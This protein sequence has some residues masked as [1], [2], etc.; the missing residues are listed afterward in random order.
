[1]WRFVT[2]LYMMRRIRFGRL[3]WK[4]R[5]QRKIDTGGMA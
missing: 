5:L 3:N 4:S 1:L 2:D